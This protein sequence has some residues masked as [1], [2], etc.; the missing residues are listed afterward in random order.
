MEDEEAP[1]PLPL[2]V[3]PDPSYSRRC[4]FS[5]PR[6]IVV[7]LWRVWLQL[8]TDTT[9]YQLLP[10][11]NIVPYLGDGETNGKPRLSSQTSPH[12]SPCRR[13]TERR[14]AFCRS[15]SFFC[16]RLYTF[17]GQR[18]LPAARGHVEE[19]N[20]AHLPSPDPP[21]PVGFPSTSTAFPHCP[22]DTATP[23]TRD[24]GC[25]STPVFLS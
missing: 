6:R 17:G 19:Y 18:H 14:Q 16:R 8:A 20:P 15:H 25:C 13:H 7:R 21:R 3:A 12:S 4:T 5:N 2:A 22:V 11:L 1:A 9:A 23:R 10:L 24:T